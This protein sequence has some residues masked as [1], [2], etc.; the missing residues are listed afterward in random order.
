MRESYM[1]LWEIATELNELSSYSADNSQYWTAKAL[2]H[3]AEEVELKARKYES[4]PNEN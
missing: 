1:N 3:L 4:E 2:L